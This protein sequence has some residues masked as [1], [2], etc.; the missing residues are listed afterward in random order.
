LDSDTIHRR[1]WWIQVILSLAVLVISLDNSILNVALPTIARDLSATTSQLQWMVDAYVLVYAG[2]LMTAGTLGDR[3]GRRKLLLLGTLVIGGGSL[4]ILGATNADQLIAIRGF[5]GIG[6]ALICPTTLSITTNIFDGAERPRAIAMW[7]AVSSLGMVFGPILGG[8]ILEWA[9]WT[10]VFLVNVP[11]AALIFVA[12]LKLVP[13]TRDPHP[14]GLD[15]IGALL[16]IAGLSSL[17]YGIIEAPNRGWGA[18]ETIAWIVG[19][20]AVIV[21]FIGWELRT[22]APMLD[23]RLFLSRRFG[24]ANLALTITSFALMGILFALT[25]Y[26]QFVLGFAPMAAGFAL[27][28]EVVG[29]M[30]GAAIATRLQRKVG[31]RPPV[32]LG[33]AIVAAM[34]WVFSTTGVDSHYAFVGLVMGVAGVGFGLAYIPATDSVMGSLPRERAGVGSAMNDTTR[35]VGGALGIAVLGSLLASGY[36]D[37]IAAALQGIPEAAAAAV[38]DSVG[39]AVAIADQIGGAQ[40]AAL[41]NAGQSSFVD[42]MSGALVA[43]AI[44]IA[45][46][47]AVSLVLLPGGT[48]EPEPEP[49]LGP[50]RAL[51]VDAEG[52]SA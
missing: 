28:P 51:R 23:V 52:A 12:A 46:A 41:L 17:V 26:V 31:A 45:V 33:L 19:G 39:A 4:A 16:S 32:A 35:Q 10:G 9:D 3:Y 20:L 2:L 48:F 15:P 29:L 49:E 18:A 37:S 43:G 38:R 14:G 7:A 6:A 27:L 22:R 13:E 36:K 1:R 50:G 40:G 34:L 30:I 47:A 24:G 21:L 8:W 5:M 11:Y 42:G 44:V 25:Q